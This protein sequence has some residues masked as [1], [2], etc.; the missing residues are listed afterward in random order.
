MRYT[1]SLQFKTKTSDYILPVEPSI[2]GYAFSN[3]EAA[4]SESIRGDGMPHL[5]PLPGTAAELNSIDLYLGSKGSDTKLRYGTEAQLK[6]LRMDIKNN[7]DL[8][9]LGLHANSTMDNRWN[10]QIFFANAS[11]DS[12]DVLYSTELEYF[13][14]SESLV[15]LSA[16]NTATGTEL[17]AEGI[18]SLARSCL[19]AGAEEV[20]ASLWNISD[21]EASKVMINFY[22]NLSQGNSASKSLHKAK[23]LYLNEVTNAQAAFPGYWAG[24]LSFH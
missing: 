20:V 12:L 21:Q 2:L 23:L 14:L 7:F 10:N 4:I 5:D 11:N 17:E 18:Y 22:L 1:Y 6:Q 3:A 24:L 15:V 13:P 16:C 8:I 9:H 19:I